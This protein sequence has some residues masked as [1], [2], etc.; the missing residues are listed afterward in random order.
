[1]VYLEEDDEHNEPMLRSFKDEEAFLDYIGVTGRDRDEVRQELFSED[2]EGEY[3]DEDGDKWTLLT[4][5]HAVARADY[6]AR[7]VLAI[8]AGQE[9]PLQ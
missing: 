2:G 4:E 1:M 8:R 5:A 7:V 6:W 9:A 3:R